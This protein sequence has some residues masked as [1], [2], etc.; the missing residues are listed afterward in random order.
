MILVILFIAVVI[1]GFVFIF[2]CNNKCWDFTFPVLLMIVGI[3]GC[4]ICGALI[5]CERSAKAYNKYYE[6]WNR[7]Y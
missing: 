2:I 6:E 7:K 4:F 1:L 3:F 5:P